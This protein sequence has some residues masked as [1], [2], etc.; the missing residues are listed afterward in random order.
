MCVEC[1]QYISAGAVAVAAVPAFA[2]MCMLSGKELVLRFVRGC[3]AVLRGDRVMSQNEAGLVATC[4][5]PC[6]I[7]FVPGCGKAGARW[8]TL[9][10]GHA[11]VRIEM[12]EGAELVLEDGSYL[13]KR[14]L[15]LDARGGARVDFKCDYNGYVLDIVAG[16]SGP[17]GGGHVRVEG[18]GHRVGGAVYINAHAG[19]V[20]QGFVCDGSQ[21]HCRAFDGGTIDV[22]LTSAPLGMFPVTRHGP[23]AILMIRH[24]DLANQLKALVVH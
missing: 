12:D 10:A 1:R 20:V 9:P 7:D 22:T 3:K 6:V 4:P 11:I 13:S 8:T 16:R 14:A 2:T 21:G 24:T 18:H 19:A 15:W 17:V 5:A 23:N